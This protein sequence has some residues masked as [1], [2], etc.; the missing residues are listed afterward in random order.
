MVHRV[1]TIPELLA[2]I[3]S[4][5]DKQSNAANSCVNKQWSNIALDTIWGDVDDLHKLFSLLV[6]LAEVRGLYAYVRFSQRGT[7]CWQVLI[8]IISIRKP[9][10]SLNLPTGSDS[11]DTPA[12]SV[13]C[14]ISSI[15]RATNT[16][17]TAYSTILLVRV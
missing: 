13:S 5:L 10:G 7:S 11:K 9:L 17:T 16:S 15:H 1:L 12:E 6:P 8:P 2:L 14:A 3:F 4:Y